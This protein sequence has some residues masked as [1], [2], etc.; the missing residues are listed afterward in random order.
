MNED[1]LSHI[2]KAVGD[3]TRRHILTLLVQEG[4]SRVTALA[5]HFDMSLNSVSKH[6]KVLEEAG[7]VT[8]KTLGREHFIA[9][10]L[11]PVREVEN[12]FAELK[13]VW[14]LRLTAL[15][16]VLVSKEQENE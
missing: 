13:S 6:I 12:W 10:E 1:A 2:L 4:P 11:E 5:A 9:A 3:V 14:E 7:L 15:E 16:D 8:R